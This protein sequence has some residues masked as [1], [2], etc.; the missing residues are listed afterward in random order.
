MKLLH[1]LCAII[2]LLFVVAH[3]SGHAIAAKGIAEY[4]NYLG[5]VRL[6]Y[7]HPVYEIILIVVIFIQF[8][9]GLFLTIHSFSRPEKRKLLSWIELIAAGLFVVFIII[10][11]TAIVV[12]RYYF[13]IETDFY[14]VASLMGPSKLQYYIVAFHFI[15]ALAVLIHIAVGLT[16]L[17]QALNIPRL[18]RHLAIVFIA[19]GTL[20]VILGLLAF[21]GVFYPIDLSL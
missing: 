4:H 15:G 16:Y 6:F 3:L 11:L 20:A 5:M 17:F 10:H 13:E 9:S 2:I 1:R 21:M 19:S 8:L 7:R 14:W 18:G 12:T